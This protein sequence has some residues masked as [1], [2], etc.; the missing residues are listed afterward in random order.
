MALTS[1]G[2]Q[3]TIIDESNYT[4]AAAG[5]VPFIVLATAQDKT[6]PNGDLAEY[7]TAANAG[8]VFL[9]TSQRELINKYGKPNY[10]VS[11]GTPVHG[12]ELNEHGLFAAYSALGVSNAAYIVRADI[13]LNELAG[14][15]ARPTGG[16]ANNTLW[17][18]VATTKF[19]IF[20]WNQSTPGFSQV[21]TSNVT[22]S[23]KLFLLTDPADISGSEP[24]NN[25]GKPGD[26]AIDLTNTDNPLFY[27]I[28]GPSSYSLYGTWAQVGTSDW[29]LG[30]PA[31]T[32]TTTANISA[33]T[34]NVFSI[35]GSN[36]TVGA[37]L[38]AT[39][40]NV[41]LVNSSNIKAVATSNGQLSV[42]C[43][44]NVGNVTFLNVTGT[45]LTTLGISANVAYNCPSF[46]DSKH[47]QAPAGGT[48]STTGSDPRPT[49]SVWF[50]TTSPNN[51]ASFVVK[52]YSSTSETW[53]ELVTP[54]Y[55][56]DAAAI[57]ALDPISGGLAIASGKTY[58][59]SDVDANNTATFKLFNR[60]AGVTSVTGGNVAPTFVVSEQFTVRYTVAGNAAIQ[61]PTTVTISGGTNA[62][63]FVSSLNNANIPNVSAGIETSGAIT[64]TH[65]LGGVLELK[66]TSG[67]P[68]ADAG[69]TTISTGARASDVTSGAIWVSN[70]RMPAYTVDDNEPSADPADG[71]YWYYNEP[72]EYDILINDGSGWRGYLNGGSDSRGFNLANTDP[73]GPI[74]SASEPTTQNS[75]ASLVSGDLWINTDNFEDFPKIYRYNAALAT[76]ILIDN[77]D[78]TSSDGIIFADARWG[79]DGSEDVITDDLPTIQDL[80]S[81]D[82]TDP[83]CPSYAEYPRGILLFNTRRSGMNV[84]QFVV[85]AF[86]DYDNPPS[87]LNAW[88]SA[89]GNNEYG[90]AYLGRRA[91]RAL[92]A[93]KMSAAVTSSV[94]A[95]E[96]TRNFNLMCAPGYP[97]LTSTLT[98]LNVNRKETAFI[99]VDSPLRLEADSN[100]LDA[101]SR[102]L[103]LA[104]DNNEQGFV[105]YYEY[106]AGYYPA[107]FTRDLDGNYCVVPSSHMV[108][109]S[110][111]R[112]DQKSYPWFAPAGI[113]RGTVDNATAIGYIDPATGL[114]QSIGVNNSLRD[115]LYNGKVN[116]ISV[117]SDSGITIYG[118]K[119][120]SATTSA[121][122]RV[123]VSRLVVYL[124]RQL[125][126][127]ARQYIFEPN[128]EITRKEIKNQIE[129]ELNSIKVNRGLYDYAVVCDTSNNTPDRV[130]RNEL[131]V[132]VAIEPV[133]AVEFIYIPVRI[134]NTGDI[135][136]GL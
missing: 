132:D 45:P 4:P 30:W 20:E 43:N 31:V 58:I 29:Q 38:T 118:Q 5:T 101:W 124:R 40:A 24:V 129:K 36:V 37:N 84:K 123:N 16:V 114:F 23:A 92:V 108:L 50:K 39:V 122:D 131:W 99:I 71:T 27:K 52:R 85:N 89:S 90:V 135:Q 127:I 28:A 2:V 60:R 109:R 134:K 78:S 68:L 130:D 121:L 46:V 79:V 133:K 15:S 116:P 42:Y 69:I 126:L 34:G 115:V 55:T 63:A 67:T 14:S 87:Y 32:G 112:S 128:D 57:Y 102:N 56:N 117:L 64:V 3:V 62:A 96:E 91:Q 18:D 95:V 81:Y 9:V 125:D 21:S 47:T 88:V 113:R 82:Y 106:M 53:T 86:A 12:Y 54:V 49:G 73:N 59:Q 75:G 120:R 66:D 103:N 1:P 10:L 70:W 80:L 26:Y 7:T 100:S 6:N 19:G 98:Q 72:T 61:G 51:G 11:A 22:G 105:S 48:W 93:A 136:A 35:N 8:K 65:A 97:E 119:T 76:W 41:N 17:L 111:I 13:D 104:V 25:V 94:E 74:V 44:S 77:T 83:D 33:I 107:G 110:I